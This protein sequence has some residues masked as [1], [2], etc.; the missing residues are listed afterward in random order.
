MKSEREKGVKCK[1]KR[2]KGERKRRKGKEK[3][4]KGGKNIIFRK[5][6]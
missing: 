1:R 6:E 5:G 3:D 4:A 2:K